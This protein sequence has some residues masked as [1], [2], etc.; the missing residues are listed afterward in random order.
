MPRLS[1]TPFKSDSSLS[2]TIFF[3]PFRCKAPFELDCLDFKA[4]KLR[5]FEAALYWC[6][7]LNFILKLASKWKLQTRTVAEKYEILK[8]IDKGMN[9]ATAIRDYNVPQQTLYGSMKEKKK[10][11]E[12]MHILCSIS[13]VIS[14]NS[15]DKSD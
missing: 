5:T 4:S 14:L 12:N 10:I 6:S 8:E 1:R 11:Y 3:C 9:C 13:F 15:P 2:W 7:N